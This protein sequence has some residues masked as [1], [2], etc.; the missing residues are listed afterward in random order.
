MPS[1]ND[2]IA[3]LTLGAPIS[4]GALSVYPLERGTASS[5]N[6]YLVLD[7]AIATGRFRITEV[8]EAGTVP[9]LLALNETGNQV[10][11]LDG[12]ELIG[13]KQ[14]RVL[15]LSLM[16]AP[17]SSTEIP[18]SCVEAGRWRSQSQTFS[19]ADRAQYARGRSQKMDQVSQSLRMCAEPACVQSLVWEEIS[20]K[21]RR[22]DVSSPTAAMG[23]I[24]ESRRGDLNGYLGAFPATD[25]QVGAVYAIGDT[26]AGLE[27][28]DS[29]A[30]FGKLAHKLVASYALDAMEHP[31]APAPAGADVVAAFLAKVRAATPE[32]FDAAGVGETVRLSSDA[33]VGAALEVEGA[34]V[35][36]SALRRDR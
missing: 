2:F 20:A 4:H 1:I 15:N 22:M 13:A 16:M 31:P 26:I 24:F 7:E 23:D 18:V 14:N 19:S 5:R 17:G 33:V 35:H 3:T 25:R 32:Q 21:S 29:A 28:F 27:V 6:G 12:E 9:R 10:F 11:L 30:T 8:S 34:W 36:L